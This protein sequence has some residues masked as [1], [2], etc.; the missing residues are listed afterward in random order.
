MSDSAIYVLICIWL[1]LGLACHAC[2]V[3]QWVA[4]ALSG[5]RRARPRVA[6]RIGRP[7]AVREPLVHVATR[8][9][10]AEP[11]HGSRAAALTIAAALAAPHAFGQTVDPAPAAP[12]IPSEPAQPSVSS[13]R[14]SFSDGTGIQPTLR[15]NLEAGYTFAFNR[16]DGVETQ[17]HNAPEVLLRLGV[18]EDRLELRFSTSGYVWSRTDDDSGFDSSGGW[19]DATLGIKLKLLDQDGWVPRLALGAQTTLGA[20]SRETSTRRVEP[21]LKLLWSYDLSQS[22]GDDWKGF[23]IGGNANVAWPT[24]DGDRFTQGQ[25]SIY[26]TVPVVEDLSAFIEYYAVGPATKGSGTAQSV[27]FG[28]LYL[29]NS[30]VQ[31]DARVGF[32]LNDQ[33]DDLFAGAGISILF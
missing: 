15:L 20:G 23:T 29:L 22:F 3:W 2:L 4:D 13:D 33:A 26:L 8:Q 12:T 32:G 18:I 28:V 14:P 11:R 1:G 17:R 9:P 30:R 7:R 16:R 24:T 10:A 6:A 31:L 27:D 25:G 19:S 5:R 21:T